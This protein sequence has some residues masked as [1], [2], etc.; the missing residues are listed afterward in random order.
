MCAALI[1]IP[2]LL[3]ASVLSH[4]NMEHVSLSLDDAADRLNVM[5]HQEKHSYAYRNYLPKWL[6]GSEDEKV[7]MS[8]REK[9]CQ[10][11]YNVVD[12]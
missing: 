5:R 3:L 11:S 6:T 1:R 7:N 4:C 2:L 10:W 12:Q 8:W 9:I